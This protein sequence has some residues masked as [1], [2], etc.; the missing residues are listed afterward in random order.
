M[1]EFKKKEI[2]Y[3][4]RIK[5]LDRICHTLHNVLLSSSY[6]HMQTAV[7][8][9]HTLHY[10]AYIDKAGGEAYGRQIEV[11]YQMYEGVREAFHSLVDFLRSQVQT[12]LAF[13][14][15]ELLSTGNFKYRVFMVD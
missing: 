6:L 15:I 13:I 11:I 3:N 14:H 1:V 10:L 2:Y 8:Y 12:H 5:T 7:N 9:L 4:M